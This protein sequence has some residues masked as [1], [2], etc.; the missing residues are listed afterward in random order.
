MKTL[1]LYLRISQDD[2]KSGESESIQN[3]RDLLYHYLKNHSEF[4]DWNILEFQDDGVSGTTF[5]RPGVQKMLQLCGSTITCIL[6]KDFSRFGRNLIEVGNYLDQIFP[7]LGVRFIAVTENFDSESNINK[8]HTIGLDVSLKA[9]V[10]EMYS[11]DLSQKVTC[12]KEAQM[13]K[14]FYI[15]GFAFYGYKK[16]DKEK[17]RLVANEEAAQVVRRIFTMAADGNT[18]REIAIQLNKE[19]ILTPYRYRK[20]RKVNPNIVLPNVTEHN[21][22]TQISVRNIIADERYTGCYIGKKEKRLDISTKKRIAIPE[23]EWIRV[24]NVHEALVSKELFQ[25]AGTVLIKKKKQKPRAN[26]ELFAGFLKCQS[27]GRILHYTDCKNPSFYCKTRNCSPQAECASIRISKEELQTGILTAIKAEMHLILQTEKM[28]AEGIS[29]EEVINKQIEC[30]HMKKRKSKQEQFI[31]FERFTDGKLVKE[32]FNIKKQCVANRIAELNRY[33]ADLIEKLKNL[34]QEKG[35][36]LHE[37]LGKYA[38]ANTL[39]REI[40]I[41]L[42][43]EIKVFPDNRIEIVWNFNFFS[44]MS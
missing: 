28:I 26:K 13:R 32:D 11:R 41:E 34:E 30:L 31:L 17:H 10:Y 22:W 42:I 37:H 18:P 39:T 4:D 12:V 9:M 25:K 14:G 24:E 2:G 23:K 20:E 29:Q 15:G 8:G 33:Q 35:Y 1:A 44:C 16:S 40:L 6:V 38:C 5:Q 21:L 36:N 43:R 19:E 27:C 3:Q 7:F